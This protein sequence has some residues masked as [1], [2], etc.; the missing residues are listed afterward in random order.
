MPKNLSRKPEQRLIWRICAA[1][2][3][4]ALLGLVGASTFAPPLAQAAEPPSPAAET[5]VN[6]VCDQ[7]E[8]LNA[9]ARPQ[10]T[11][12]LITTLRTA[13]AE[14]AAKSPKACEV[15]LNAALV[16][17]AGAKSL[18]GKASDLSGSDPAAA[19]VL[20]AEALKL[21]AESSQ[22]LELEATLS[23]P[24]NLPQRV[25]K[26]IQDRYTQSWSPLQNI[27]LSWLVLLLGV[28]IVARLLLPV[29]PKH[30]SGRPIRR[31]AANHATLL[32]WGGFALVASGLW[33]A[34]LNEWGSINANAAILATIAGAVLLAYGWS[35]AVRISV[36]VIDSKGDSVP[37]AEGHVIALLSQLGG[38]PP[39]GV[40]TPRGTDTTV[41]QSAGLTST[42]DVSG[43][44]RAVIAVAQAVVP[45]TPWRVRIDV[46]DNDRHC[47]TITR[48]GRAV[49]GAVIDRDE[50]GLRVKLPDASGN[51]RG[52]GKDDDYPDL[53]RMSAAAVL[54]ALQKEYGFSGACGATS[55]R[56]LGL[57]CI[58]TNDFDNDPATARDILARAVK[59]DRENRLALVAF[60][61]AQYRDCTS[62]S[63]LNK[64][65]GLLSGYIGKRLRVDE[66]SGTAPAQ[67]IDHAITEDDPADQALLL[68]VLFSQVLVGVNLWATKGQ[69]FPT[70]KALIEA[71]ERLVKTNEASLSIPECGEFARATKQAVHNLALCVTRPEQEPSDV[72]ITPRECYLYAC[73]LTSLCA[74]EPAN[75]RSNANRA[76]E[77]LKQADGDPTWRR[78][79]SEDPQL[80]YLRDNMPE[81]CQ[82]FGR[83]PFTDSEFLQKIAELQPFR[84]RLEALGFT[85]PRILASISALE[86]QTLLDVPE[87]AS[88]RIAEIA[89]LANF[90][91]N[92]RT[93]DLAN[94]RVDITRALLAL[95]VTRLPADRGHAEHVLAKLRLENLKELP[96]RQ[97]LKELLDTYPT[98]V[99]PSL[100]VPGGPWAE[101]GH[102]VPPMRV[103]LELQEH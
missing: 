14:P 7:A 84:K 42:P 47:I 8:Q 92:D 57:H 59:E 15:Q 28:L 96:S 88:L 61:H 41:L 78:W 5:T 38:S 34:L 10:Q 52:S 50:L 103:F 76:I 17:T 63:Q 13:L 98:V 26:Q 32:M 44:L 90:P 64:Y 81:Y 11:I 24:P 100:P 91:T 30:D 46:E 51:P 93:K 2:G 86:L 35:R 97:Q 21:D 94:W 68:R 23:N 66:E 6:A 12:E 77:Y 39:R 101:N 45:A 22:A 31:W 37:S 60:W 25:W 49:F 73:Y 79:R 72:G 33:I 48:N 87:Q 43:F 95:G 62:H 19:L 65:F 74:T 80:K 71:K 58:A 85:T 9:Q 36:S 70:D 18:A 56:S 40:E 102:L 99:P 29:F 67:E 4:T 16:N 53:H 75:S 69:Y 55:W 20:V 89:Q 83:Q 1:A 54:C 27:F 82:E 3:V